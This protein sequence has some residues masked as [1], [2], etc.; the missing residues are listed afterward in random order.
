MPFRTDGKFQELW[1]YGD[2]VRVLTDDPEL[3]YLPVLPVDMGVKNAITRVPIGT[4]LVYRGI[5]WIPGY[6]EEMIPFLLFDFDRAGGAT[7]SHQ[8]MIGANV[9]ETVCKKQY[10]R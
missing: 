9:A 1:R 2:T 7:A 4:F 8:I 3:T 10:H 5:K 6:G